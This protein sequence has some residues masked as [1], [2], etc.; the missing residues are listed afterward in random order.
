MAVLTPEHVGPSTAACLLEVDAL[1]DPAEAGSLDRLASSIA[2]GIRRYMGHPSAVRDQALGP[3]LVVGIIGVGIA[4]FSLANAI[5]ARNVGGLTWRR[6]ITRCTHQYP[7]GT[8]PNPWRDWYETILSVDCWPVPGFSKAYA[9]FA[10]YFRANG[11]DVDQCRV[12]KYNSTD[13]T[14]SKLDVT[15]E[16]QDAVSYEQNSVG[17][18]MLY[19]SGTLDPAGSG[20]ID[21]NGSILVKADTSVTA[22]GDL[23]VSR[24]D[25][26]DFEIKRL[27]SG[28]GFSI[29]KT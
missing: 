2:A 28:S 18:I 10:V 13:W 17:A 1:A 20:D 23:S 5:E 6:N 12:E 9:F 3:E 8:Q 7:S 19:L 24:G 26:S 21:F 27:D 29:R 11:N 22:Q 16:G 25:A 14:I 15:F 4:T